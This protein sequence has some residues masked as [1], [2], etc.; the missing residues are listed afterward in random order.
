MKIR[1]ARVAVIFLSLLALISVSGGCN[2]EGADEPAA[3]LNVILVSIDTTRADHLGCYG[4]PLLKTPNIDRLAAEGVRFEQCIV[5]APVT[6]PSHASMLTGVYPFVHKVR[7]NGTFRLHAD[8][9][10]LAEILR[11]AGYA[12][13]AQVGAFVM[14]QSFGLDQGFDVYRDVGYTLAE[15]ARE[16]AGSEID[17]EQVTDGAIKLLGRVAPGPFF[18]FVHYFDPHQPYAPPKRL[19]DKYFDPYSAEIAF[20]DEQL[21]RL[22]DALAEQGL[23]DDTLIVLTSD[24]GEGL[25]QHGETT[26]AFFVYDTTLRVPLIFWSPGRLPAGWTTAECVR[27]IDIAPTILALLG[28]APLA[29]GQGVDL[30]P[31]W[32]TPLAELDLEAYSETFYTKYNLGYS[33][34]RALR[35]DGWKYILSPRP[36][37][38]HIADDPLET[39]DLA[40]AQ[41]DRLNDMHARLRTIIESARQ[42]VNAEQSRRAVSAGEIRR[43]ESL[44]Y[45]GGAPDEEPAPPGGELALFEPTGSNPMDHTREIR[46]ASHAVGLSQTGR[47]AEIEK[48][49]REL[50]ELTGEDAEKFV[51]AHAHL[52]GALAAQGKLE[53]ALIHFDLAIRARPEDGQMYTMKGIVLRALKK[54]DQAL[55]MFRQAVELEPVFAATH[56]NLAEMSAGRGLVDEAVEQYRL[57]IGK[58]PSLTRAYRGLAKLSAGGARVGEV[59]D[60]LDREIA[61]LRAA[62]DVLGA[63]ELQALHDQL[64]SAPAAP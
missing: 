33:Q 9:Q 44:G 31:L 14:N 42:V 52:A 13:A 50:L 8:N 24:H 40:A 2:G 63:S 35:A 57:A 41:P 55:A 12:T 62:G 51:W 39:R 29:H 15:E 6:L 47:H 56:L 45:V 38:Y 46:L 54:N 21:G 5:A 48:T 4:H 28:A 64:R 16:R 60:M 18:M 30:S 43:L 53:E 3:K 7:D 17:A 11:D 27:S 10:T 58:D 32:R 61:K 36:E 19:A 26:H 59:L 49:I 1:F 25:G 34:L 22:L 23:D 20:V 37:L